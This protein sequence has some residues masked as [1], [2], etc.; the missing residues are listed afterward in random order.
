[1]SAAPSHFSIML[2]PTDPLWG[3]SRGPLYVT[4][5]MGW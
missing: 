1:V 3:A 4:G 5:A 2:R